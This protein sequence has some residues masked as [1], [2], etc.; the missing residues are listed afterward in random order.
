MN[1]LLDGPC[2]RNEPRKDQLTPQR[3]GPCEQEIPCIP[4]PQEEPKPPL[5]EDKEVSQAVSWNF[6]VDE[7]QEEQY[8]RQRTTRLQE[9]VL[10]FQEV[11]GIDRR[12][13]ETLKIAYGDLI[14]QF[15][16]DDEAGFTGLFEASER[17]SKR[18]DLPAGE[19]SQ[20]RMTEKTSYDSDSLTR[21]FYAYKLHAGDEDV[22]LTFLN[23]LRT[24]LDYISQLI[25]DLPSTELT[26]LTSCYHPA[27]VDLS[28]LPNHSHGRTSMYSRDSQMMKLSRRMDNIDSFHT[29]DPY[30]TL[31]FALFDTSAM[32]GSTEYQLRM[33]IWARTCAKVMTDGKDGSEEFAIA[34]IDSFASTDDWTLK[35]DLEIY[36]LQVLSEGCFIL[37]PPAED[38]GENYGPTLEPERASHAIAVAEFFDRHARILFSMLATRPPGPNDVL[39][40]IGLTLSHVQDHQMR[41]LAKKFIVSRWYFASFITSLLVYPEVRSPMWRLMSLL[42]LKTGPWTTT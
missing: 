27:G 42:I 12:L 9:Q 8:E 15:K 1:D 32:A 28:I 14:D 10:K 23:R 17:L 36:I 5:Q 38:N 37:D 34:T 31:L 22:I 24:D 11:T 19:T 13:K 33:E 29:K 16:G 21:G 4:I 41:E 35:A 2:K 3:K 18:F 26:A 40:L 39:D 20:L 6:L 25:S 30:F 7:A